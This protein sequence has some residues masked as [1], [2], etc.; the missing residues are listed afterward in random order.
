MTRPVVY[1]AGPFRASTPWGIEQNV[2][3]AEEVG[4]EVAKAGAVPLIPHAMYRFF[5][6]SL[7]DEFWLEGTLELLR[8][9]DALVLTEGWEA[10][11]GSRGEVAEA[12]RLGIPVFE[13]VAELRN[14]L[15]SYKPAPTPRQVR[16]CR[17]CNLTPVLD[18]ASEYVAKYEHVDLAGSILGRLRDAV[19][20][21]KELAR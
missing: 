11:T 5:Q 2:R 10:S 13:S 6:N 21:A 16:G 8:R 12:K 1:C 20:G 15:D 3:R 7:P 14:W 19:V 4:L 17:E 9:C 18:I